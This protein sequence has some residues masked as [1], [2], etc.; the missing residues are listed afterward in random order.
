M[1][2]EIVLQTP[3]QIRA[4]AHPLRQRILNLLVDAPYT[5][6]QLATALNVSPPR[7]HFHVR[8]LQSAGLIEMVEERPKGGV[9]EKYYR[10][11]ARVVLLNPNLRQVVSDE[12]LLETT[13]DAVRQEY[14]RAHTY[15]NGQLLNT[16][17]AHELVRLSPERLA[18][19]QEHL[20][21][22]GDAIYQALT[23]PDRETYADFV[24]ITYL[25][26]TLPPPPENGGES[27]AGEKA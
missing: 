7:L 24:S 25:L 6:K 18:S 2:N 21:A 9:V 22:V 12:E 17:F 26:H 8:E 16:L 4:L 23:D 11:V 27:A 1:R 3:E 10:A 15:F 19:I 5:N 20:R 14:I 13:L